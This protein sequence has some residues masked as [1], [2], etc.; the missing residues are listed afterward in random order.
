MTAITFSSLVRFTG[1]GA[2][3]R[4]KALSSIP[5]LAYSDGLTRGALIDAVAAASAGDASDAVISAIK[6]A[7]IAGRAASRLTPAKG[8]DEAA[9]LDHVLQLVCTYVA[10]RGAK[11]GAKVKPLP[12]GKVGERSELQH[13]AIRSAEQAWSQIAGEAGIGAAK[14]DKE[15]KGEERAK[16]KRAPH[17]NEK[18]TKAAA[19][20][21]A[22]LVKPAAKL[23]TDEVHLHVERVAADLLAFCNKYAKQLDTDYGQAAHAFK[24]AINKAAND[25]QVRKALVEAAK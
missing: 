18:A 21:H 25:R 16:A 8:Q 6:T 4:S 13:R 14:S 17:H 22:E 2:A 11:P 1:K 9:H 15:R 20:D 23:T 10:P 7:F 19:P 3:A 5:H 24:G 12:A